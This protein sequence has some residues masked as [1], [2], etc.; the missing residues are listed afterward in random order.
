MITSPAH[1]R[2]AV[3][4][5]DADTVPPCHAHPR[6][7]L[8]ISDDP[9]ERALAARLCRRCPVIELCREAGRRERFGVWAGKDRTPPPPPPGKKPTTR[10]S[11]PSKKRPTKRRTTRPKSRPLES[12][13][14]GQ[15][16]SALVI[17]AS[18]PVG[19]NPGHKRAE[20]RAKPAEKRPSPTPSK[21]RK[22]SHV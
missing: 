9:D 21:S 3:A 11:T 16:A 6:P 18:P 5:L 19:H 10:P 1:R 12:K 13:S 8:W 14:S 17:G 4:L 7:S 2:L 15:A 20:K 22:K